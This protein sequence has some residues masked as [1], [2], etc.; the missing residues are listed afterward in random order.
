MIKRDHSRT[1]IISEPVTGDMK[2]RKKQ[3]PNSDVICQTTFIL[4]CFK[5]WFLVI[6]WKNHSWSFIDTNERL[7]RILNVMGSNLCRTLQWYCYNNYNNSIHRIERITAP[8]EIMKF[9]FDWKIYVD[10]L[11]LKTS[12][13]EWK[14]KHKTNETIVF[15]CTFGVK[16]QYRLLLCFNI[17]I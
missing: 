16:M 5:L 4:Y 10:W 7:H 15:K 9:E 12:N 3:Y 13:K 8:S 11:N 2:R 14:R 17:H 6:E 1:F